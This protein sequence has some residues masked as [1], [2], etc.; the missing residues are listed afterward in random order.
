VGKNEL[1]ILNYQKALEIDD[2]DFWSLVNL[3]ALHE[4][5]G[6]Y[7][8]S[9]ELINRAAMIEPDHYMVLFNKGVLAMRNHQNK[10]AMECFN[11]TILI[12]PSYGYAYLNKGV[13]LRDMGMLEEAIKVFGIGIKNC[14]DGVYLAYNRAC[15]YLKLGDVATC[16][17]ELLVILKEY[18]EMSDYMQEDKELEHLIKTSSKI[19]EILRKDK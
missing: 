1:A 19:K 3:S 14:E 8:L 11:K 16:E 9:E 18:P 4:E 12:E 5:G 17:K 2:K 10:L 15:C 6:E 7:A 13:I